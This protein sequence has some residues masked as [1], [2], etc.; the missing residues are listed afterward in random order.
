[1]KHILVVDDS[2]ANL[3]LA[4]EALSPYYK[5]TIL[6]SGTQALAF[7]EKMTPDLILLDIE[8]PVMDGFAVV[9]ALKSRGICDYPPIIFLTALNSPA[10]EVR[11]LSMG[12]VDFIT[13]PFVA[14]TM[15]ARIGTHLKISDYQRN[16]EEMVY[17]SVRTIEELQSALSISIAE[18]V[19]CRDGYTGEHI[20][21]TCV[22]IRILAKAMQRLDHYAPHISDAYVRDLVKAAALHDIGKVGIA[23]AVL[24]KK[25]RYTDEEAEVMKRHVLLGSE[26]LGRAIAQAGDDK[27]FLP[28]AQD[29]A[30]YHHERWDGG[31]YPQGLREDNIPLAARIMAVVDVYDALTSRRPYK[32]PYSHEEAEDILREG[33]GTHFD[34][35][36]VDAFMTC[37]HTI[38]EA[39]QMQ[40]FAIAQAEMHNKAQTARVSEC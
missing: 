25:S 23:D 3:T 1:M 4:K 21:R 19:G 10:V 39:M 2:V 38:A 24:S 37:A 12:V 22:Y 9:E 14:D 35:C 29:M 32:D 40:E 5:V 30:R 27:H 6:V 26:T 20:K 33:R 7:L 17:N 34:P 36:I 16:L 18:L 8:M 11:A 13:K 15:L 31:G 28:M